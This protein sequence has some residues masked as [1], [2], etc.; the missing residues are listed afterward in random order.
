MQAAPDSGVSDVS[1]T[2]QHAD[3]DPCKNKQELCHANLQVSLVDSSHLQ[4][5]SSIQHATVHPA[6]PEVDNQLPLKF[7]QHRR[8]T[9]QVHLSSAAPAEA[10]GEARRGQLAPI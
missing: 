5:Q 2:A 1:T 7:L 8:L 6:P 9:L 4:E 3:G 10:C